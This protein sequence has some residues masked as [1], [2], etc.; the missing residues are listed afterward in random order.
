MR[1]ANAPRFSHPRPRVTPMTPGFSLCSFRVSCVPGVATAQE[2]EP[3]FKRSHTMFER[4]WRLLPTTAVAL[5]AGLIATGSF[6]LAHTGRHSHHVA[7]SHT[8][9]RDTT[10]HGGRYSEW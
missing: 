10:H 7:G 4:T 5:T 9:C 2:F 8:A 6:A 3:H 1:P